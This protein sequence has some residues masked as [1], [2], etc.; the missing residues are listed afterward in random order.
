VAQQPADSPR[1]SPVQP[2]EP[3]AA[4]HRLK[5]FQGDNVQQVEFTR[6]NDG[7]WES[8]TT[9]GDLGPR[10]RP[11]VVPLGGTARLQLQSRLPIKIIVPSRENVLKVDRVPGDPTTVRLTGRQAGVLTVELTDFDGRKEACEVIV[12]SSPDGGGS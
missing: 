8:G 10:S 2:K 3:P 11:L 12:H 9:S 7:K 5:L 1:A 4:P 6:G